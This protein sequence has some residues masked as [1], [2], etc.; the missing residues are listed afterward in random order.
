MTSLTIAAPA[1]ARGRSAISLI[2]VSGPRAF[3]IIGKIFFTHKNPGAPLAGFKPRLGLI[4]EGGAVIDEAMATL[5]VSPFSY[6]GEDMAEITCHGNPLIVNK[7]LSLLIS[8]GCALASPGEFTRRAYINGKM[9]LSRAEAVNEVISCN[10]EPAL[11]ISLAAMFGSEKE[12]VE[13]LRASLLSAISAIEADLDFDHDGAERLNY[14]EVIAVIRGLESK[15]SLMS[16]GARESVKLKEGYTLA[17][18]GRPNC[19]KSSLMNLLLKKERSIVAHLPGTTRDVIEDVL[20]I[21]GLPFRLFDTAGIRETSDPVEEEGVRRAKDIV[22]KADAVVLMVDSSLPLNNEDISLY[23][24]LMAK[25][26]I[27]ALNKSDLPEKLGVTEAQT[28]FGPPVGLLLRLCA[29][30]GEGLNDLTSAVKNI[31]MSNEAFVPVDLIT[32]AGSRHAAEAE[33]ALSCAVRALEALEKGKAPEAAAAELK[34][35]AAHLGQI[36]GGV[37]PGDVLDEIFKNFCIG[38]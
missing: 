24:A 30:S 26:T 1:T 22:N 17:I 16:K 18:T 20:D 6:T 5:F 21:D 12:A 7:I 10:S 14:T 3:E 2:R 23:G 9:D 15:L 36:A 28:A 8:H 37:T 13:G 19:G 29:A 33:N 32:A 35:A 31:I 38:K 27:I 25:K 34:N 11:K 4:K